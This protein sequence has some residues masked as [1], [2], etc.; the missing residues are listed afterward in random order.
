MD[1]IN[2]LI[3]R[4]EVLKYIHK[5]NEHHIGFISDKTKWRVLSGRIVNVN[6]ESTKF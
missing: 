2:K 1:L 4:M 5:L 6:N 3:N